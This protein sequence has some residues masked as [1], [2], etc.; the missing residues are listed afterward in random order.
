MAHEQMEEERFRDVI[1]IENI[2]LEVYRDRGTLEG[3]LQEF[4]EF[5]VFDF[6]HGKGMFCIRD[7]KRVF[8]EF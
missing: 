4:N 2:I 1:P 6:A 3:V 5:G 7:C 8:V